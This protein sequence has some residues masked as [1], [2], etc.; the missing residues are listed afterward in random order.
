M[1]T[2]VFPAGDATASSERDFKEAV[3]HSWLKQRARLAGGAFKE[4]PSGIV[5]VRSCCGSVSYKERFAGLFPLLS[6]LTYFNRL[7]VFLL[8]QPELLSLSCLPNSCYL[9]ISGPGSTKIRQICDVR[10]K[11]HE[12]QVSVMEGDFLI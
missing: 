12:E 4:A 1:R 9:S 7:L 3:K 11:K 8:V 6:C 10:R 2:R 5:A